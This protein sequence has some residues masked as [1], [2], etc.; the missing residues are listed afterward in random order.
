MDSASQSDT[1]AGEPPSIIAN[2]LGFV[3]AIATLTL[4][5]LVIDRFA[6]VPSLPPPASLPTSESQP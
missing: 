4:P 2:L 1:S 5:L 6:S 3:I